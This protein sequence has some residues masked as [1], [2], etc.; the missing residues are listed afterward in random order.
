MV[1]GE[2]SAE[3]GHALPK[4]VSS[5]HHFTHAEQAEFHFIS[6]I[7]D[8]FNRF[9]SFHI[10]SFHFTALAGFAPKAPF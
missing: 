1:S 9:R 2:W 7:S 4:I 6:R 5:F 3:S 8:R 10:V